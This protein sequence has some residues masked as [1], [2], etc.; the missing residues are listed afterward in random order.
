MVIR[1]HV[2]F[3]TVHLIRYT[4]VKYITNDIYVMASYSVVNNT[5]TLSCTKTRVRPL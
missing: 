1:A 3:H 4:I 5:F 2:I